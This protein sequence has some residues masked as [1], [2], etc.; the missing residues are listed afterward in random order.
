MTVNNCYSWEKP[1]H[2]CSYTTIAKIGKNP[3]LSYVLARLWGENMTFVIYRIERQ[4]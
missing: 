2:I 4:N 3:K 1:V